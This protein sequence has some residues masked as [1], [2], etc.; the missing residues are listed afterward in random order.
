MRI[1][2]WKI[3]ANEPLTKLELYNLKNDPQET[4]ELSAAEPAKFA[5]MKSALVQLNTELEAE[6]PNWW[7][8]Y[9]ESTSKKK[10]E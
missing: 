10:A 5:E 6:G 2:D 3:L 4:T 7:K 8:T 9:E 1:G